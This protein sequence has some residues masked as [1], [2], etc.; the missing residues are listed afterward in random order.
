MATSRDNED[1]RSLAS[2]VCSGNPT[3]RSVDA[4]AAGMA[5][6]LHHPKTADPT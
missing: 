1:Q 4:S 3:L 6:F 2:K 5:G